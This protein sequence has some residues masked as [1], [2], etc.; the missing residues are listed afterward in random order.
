MNQQNLKTIVRGA[1][2]I[3]KLRIQMGNRIVGNFK[4]KLGQDA[5]AKEETLDEDAKAVLGNL[6][7]E[8]KKI[9]DGVKKFP[10][11]KDFEG[12][13]VISDFTELCLV[14]Q[15]VG[16]EKHEHE[17][18][19]RLG[20][21]LREYPVFSKFLDD[22]NGV[23]P[24]MAGVIVSEIDISKARYPSS[25]WA[26][27]GLDSVSKWVWQRT[28]VCKANLAAEAPAV[29]VDMELQA[30]EEDGKC[31]IPDG[32]VVLHRVADDA[33]E[34]EPQEGVFADAD[35]EAFIKIKRNGFEYD[36]L[37]RQF[38]CGG[39]SRRKE[40]LRDVE[41]TDKDGKKAIRKG[42]TFNPFLKT[43]LTGVLGPS[44]LKVRESPYKDVYYDYKHRLESHAKYGVDTD[45]S[46]GRRHNM[47]I[48]Y[49]VKRF[50]V[51]LYVA[52]RTIEGLP[53]AEEYSKAK[54]GI[55]HAA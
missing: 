12:T 27:A 44:F 34:R 23:G 29:Q 9:T 32:E 43:K 19:K 52:W 53:V 47:A 48:R 35:S 38:H 13:E 41:Y 28:T 26:Y 40:H 1:Y 21:I 14:A 15:Y 18:F 16:L 50:L 3:Q 49:A 39:R 55:E 2:D 31:V 22:V 54:L 17:H 10:K 42:I 8:F 7:T 24:A 36:C 11:Q 37:Y 4:A 5:G 51:D 20:Q 46:K 33:F 25:L 30:I 6:R 45:T